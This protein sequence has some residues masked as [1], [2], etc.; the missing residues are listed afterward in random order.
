MRSFRVDAA[1][2][3]PVA[4]RLLTQ[5]ATTS[6]VGDAQPKRP[7]RPR[8]GRVGL[9][10]SARLDLA[11]APR[12]SV[13]SAGDAVS[14]HGAVVPLLP[15]V[16][17]VHTKAATQVGGARAWASLG[18]VGNGSGGV[19]AGVPS[20]NSLV[21]SAT[22]TAGKNDATRVAVA[23]ATG[24]VTA[25]PTPPPA[26]SKP[27]FEKR[28]SF[29]RSFVQRLGQVRQ[30][31]FRALRQL[32]SLP[33]MSSRNVTAVPAP[34]GRGESGNHLHTN[35]MPEIEGT[36]QQL[37]MGRRVASESDTSDVL[38]RA[39]QQ[40]DHDSVA[41]AKGKPA[42]RVRSLD[43]HIFAE[44]SAPD[45]DDA[46]VQ[47]QP[48][49]RSEV[50]SIDDNGSGAAVLLTPHFFEGSRSFSFRMTPSGAVAVDTPGERPV[51]T[52]GP[53]SAASSTTSTAAPSGKIE[54][55]PASTT[56]LS[57]AQSKYLLPEG[58]DV[59]LPSP[60][61][62][63]R[64][65]M[66]AM[67]RIWLA[68]ARHSLLYRSFQLNGSSEFDNEVADVA[69][70]VHSWCSFASRAVASSQLNSLSCSV[71]LPRRRAEAS[72]APNRSPPVSGASSV[73]RML[74]YSPPP[75]LSRG[76]S[77][78]F[79]DWQSQRSLPLD[80][81][82][83]DDTDGSG[84]ATSGRANGGGASSTGLGARHASPAA[85]STA[86]AQASDQATPVR[87]PMLKMTSF[88]SF[89]SAS[90]RSITNRSLCGSPFSYDKDMPTLMARGN[91]HGRY[92]AL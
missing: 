18:T 32:A 89:V 24:Q 40:A 71:L 2:A 83:D 4:R 16:A 21:P 63:L 84:E 81:V 5:S 45:A 15:R 42:P 91:E 39:V 12:T 43:P 9:S 58:L 67:L 61:S 88:R 87:P 90:N 47:V 3:S 7:R 82:P 72:D 27:L 20:E 41:A 51:A 50:S 48:T 75:S 77:A 62:R 10:P 52:A 55:S 1:G 29:G 49:P 57:P 37:V 30:R 31:S 79:L 46:E 22:A 73:Q 38:L 53:P 25:Y 65:N 56:A 80:P 64:K 60:G 34:S 54:S 35:S 11:A 76:V 68:R 33:S 8:S 23:A 44:L 59:T 26:K 36:I 28:A 70:Y 74:Q 69:L 78:K 86:S 14:P 85:S 92:V 66:A 6:P 17:S 13:V 19:G